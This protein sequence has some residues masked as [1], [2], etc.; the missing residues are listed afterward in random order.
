MAYPLYEYAFA[1]L[2]KKALDEVASLAQVESWDYR[3]TTAATPKPILFNYL[4]NT[5][6]RAQEQGKVLE[7]KNCSCFNT[8]LVTPNYEQIFAFFVP[9]K[10]SPGKTQKWKLQDF[11][12]E[13]DHRLFAFDELPPMATYFDNPA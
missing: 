11:L 6:A 2:D 7:I 9:H 13:S 5:F 3:G 4:Q 8:G 10:A 12:K 1:P